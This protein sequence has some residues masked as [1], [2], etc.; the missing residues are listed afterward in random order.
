MTMK[1]SVN[2]KIRPTEIISSKEERGE[3][4]KKTTDFRPAG[5]HRKVYQRSAVPEEGSKGR[6]EKIFKEI[7]TEKSLALQK[8]FK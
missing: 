4:I 7:M 1:A 2:V 5:Q 6:M 8:K 3:K